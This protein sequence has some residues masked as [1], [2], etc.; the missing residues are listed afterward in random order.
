MPTFLLMRLKPLSP[1][2][3][4][5]LPRE[6]R[7]VT[8]SNTVV[9]RADIPRGPLS[10]ML[11]LAVA[12]GRAVPDADFAC[13]EVML[14]GAKKQMTQSKPPVEQNAE[15]VIDIESEEDIE[16]VEE[17][18]QTWW[19]MLEDGNADEAL[20]ALA[21]VQTL[22]PDERLRIRSYLGSGEALYVAF[23]CRAVRRLKWKSYTIS[24]RK[25]FGHESP[26]VRYEA[27]KTVGEM[28]GPSMSP[29][30]HLLMSDPDEKVQVAARKAYKKLRR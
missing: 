29:A 14:P 17:E 21:K 11:K 22:S 28:A 20:D 30:V 1:E 9:A 12:M 5:N 2:E 10:I 24:L 16:S 6:C 27:V 7:V 19:E 4:R 15:E 13:H 23:V 8:D 3:I 25:A 18:P 26:I